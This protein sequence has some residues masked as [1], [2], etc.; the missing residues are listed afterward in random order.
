M[1]GIDLVLK[2]DHQCSSARQVSFTI[3]H[4]SL[5]CSSALA[6]GCKSVH[7]IA[8]IISMFGCA[9]WLPDLECTEVGRTCSKLRQRDSL[10]VAVSLRTSL[11]IEARY[12]ALS[13]PTGT[14]C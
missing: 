9:R 12:G 13:G 3:L 4:A 6:A 1:T 2:S 11:Q 8:H 14:R 5:R 10:S 7:K